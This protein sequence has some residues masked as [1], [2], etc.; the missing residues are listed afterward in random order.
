ME[1]KELTSEQKVMVEENINLVYE[2][3]K[4]YMKDPDYD[5]IVGEGYLA[6]SVAA[7]RY[8][9]SIGAFST[10]AY[11]YISGYIK[12]FRN[13]NKTIR[14]TRKG[15][16]YIQHNCLSLDDEDLNIQVRC[17]EENGE[18]KQLIEE[19]ISEVRE[20]YKTIL[21]MYYDG[22]SQEQIAESIGMSQSYVSNK[23]RCIGSKYKD[24]VNSRLHPEESNSL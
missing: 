6:L 22:H 3:T 10:Y 8:D 9:C 15:N 14:P 13:R 7:Q 12:V 1:F 5:D 20:P 16:Q 19:I 21:C 24:L 2:L 4:G 11:H 23:L 17:K 18:K